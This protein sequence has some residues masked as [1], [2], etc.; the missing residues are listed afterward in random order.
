MRAVVPSARDAAWQSCTM[1]ACTRMACAGIRAV[2]EIIRSNRPLAFSDRLK[3]NSS[4][5]AHCGL[6][7]KN[8]WC[9]ILRPAR[10]IYLAPYFAH[11]CFWYSDPSL[12]LGG[13]QHNF[14]GVTSHNNDL[15][16]RSGLPMG[17]KKPG[18]E[19]GPRATPEGLARNLASFPPRES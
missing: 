4:N 1:T 5:A 9:L 16:S 8:G 10:I 18:Y 12:P 13:Y 11:R 3:L 6:G 19:P 14:P 17:G 15:P 2:P 7:V